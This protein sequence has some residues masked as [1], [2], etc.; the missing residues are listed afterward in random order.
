[1]KMK[2]S[3]K[4]L[5]ITGAI[6]LAI[7]IGFLIGWYVTGIDWMLFI[8]LVG[9]V[10]GVIVLLVGLSNLIAETKANKNINDE[11]T[12][13]HRTYGGAKEYAYFSVILDRKGQAARNVAVNV[14]GVFGMIFGGGGLFVSG[15]TSHDIF[16]NDEE[17]VLNC[18]TTNKKLD[19]KKFSVIPA[20]A[21]TDVRFETGKKYETVIVV[22]SAGALTFEV[23][24]Y[25]ENDVER[26]RESFLRLLPKKQE[27]DVFEGYS[28]QKAE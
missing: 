17:L 7:G 8:V 6:F 27:V 24:I 25:N 26:V 4:P 10:A 23:R 13:S 16:V 9:G 15:T 21:V 2:Q 11:N 3:A 22:H 18:P 1:M 20:S 28:E 19:D 12:I 14:L 5:L